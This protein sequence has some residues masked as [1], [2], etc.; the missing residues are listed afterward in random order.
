MPTPTTRLVNRIRRDFPTPGSSDEVIARLTEL[1]PDAYGRQD[2]ERV[3]AAL[4]LAAR[5]QWSR[6]AAGMELLRE[7]WRDVL[8][9]GG[10]AEGDW[11]ERLDAE[12][13]DQAT[14]P[15]AE[16]AGTLRPSRRRP[17]R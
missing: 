7:D 4:V 12:L 15:A 9:A 10:L 11:P 13:P 2:A 17:A 8:V 3:Q 1:P 14:P 6:F 5:G 16:R